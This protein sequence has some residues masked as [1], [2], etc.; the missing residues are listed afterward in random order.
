VIVDSL[1]QSLVGEITESLPIDRSQ[2]KK[3]EE[4]REDV[5]VVDSYQNVKEERREYIEAYH[6][7]LIERELI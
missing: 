5:Y 7:H 1:L 4:V 3:K 2:Q 6:R